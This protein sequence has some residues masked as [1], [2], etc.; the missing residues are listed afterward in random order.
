M[1]QKA[2]DSVVV[3]RTKIIVGKG[4]LETATKKV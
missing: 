1:A 4:K 2:C 3:Q